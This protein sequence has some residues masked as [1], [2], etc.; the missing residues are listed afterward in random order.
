MKLQGYVSFRHFDENMIFVKFRK[1]SIFGKMLKI[2]I[3]G[4]S[5]ILPPPEKSQKIT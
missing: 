4:K 5:D 1:T 2:H 3:F